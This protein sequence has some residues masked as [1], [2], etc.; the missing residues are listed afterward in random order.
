MY[1]VAVSDEI[2]IAHSLKH[3]GFGPAQKVHGATLTITIQVFRSHLDEMNTVVDLG[4]L[5][6]ILSNIKGELHYQNLDNLSQ[7]DATLTTIDY[8]IQ[9]IWDQMKVGLEM[10]GFPLGKE[11]L[12]SM[13][14]RID[15]S[16]N[17]WATYSEKF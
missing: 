7:F 14:V 10:H 8:L 17:A 12:H 16:R 4:K 13:K 1:S 5:L 15:E 3:P 2:F 9:Y 6:D 11:G